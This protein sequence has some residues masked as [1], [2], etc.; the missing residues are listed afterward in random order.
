MA[1]VLWN[2]PRLRLV[3]TFVIVGF[4]TLA[5]EKSDAPQRRDVA[6][7]VKMVA[8]DS[9]TNSPVLVLAEDDASRTLPI[10]IGLSEARSIASQLEG[11]RATR[12]NTHDLAE[13]LI[14]ELEGTVQRVVVTDL[15]DG[16]Y[17]ATTE[18]RVRGQLLKI[19]S[20]PSDAVAIALRAEAPLFVREGLF[21]EADDEEP[22]GEGPKQEVRLRPPFDALWAGSASASRHSR[23]SIFVKNVATAPVAESARP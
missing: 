2:R 7:H 8:L 3:S 14:H 17:F 19:D 1:A 13:Q 15:R 10:W 22:R 12:P 6:V 5:C 18:L 20:R 23:P 11:V 16:I 9:N 21:D 4:G